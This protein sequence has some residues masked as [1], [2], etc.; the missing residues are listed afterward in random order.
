VSGVLALRT[1]ALLVAVVAL[2]GGCRQGT[3]PVSAPP[4]EPS[5]EPTIQPDDRV[6]LTVYFRNGAG[7]HLVPV[8]REVAVGDDLPRR[9]M[10][11]LLAGPNDEE[12]E[13]GG[14]VAPLPTTTRI[15][16]FTVDSGTAEVDLSAHVISDAQEVGATPENEVLALA[17]IVGTLTEFPAIDR[18]RLAV[19]GVTSGWRGGV[20]VGAFWGGWGLPELLVRDET[21]LGEPSRDADGVPDLALFSGDPQTLGA[22]NGEPVAIHTVRMR[23]RTTYLRLAVGITDPEDPDAPGAVPQARAR[24]DG[25]SILVEIDGVTAYTAEVSAGQRLAV[26]DPAFESLSVELTE[27]PGTVRLRLN[28]AEARSFV[29]HRLSS[30][31]RVVLDVKK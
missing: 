6:D 31:T 3:D 7:G 8:V 26:D 17:A 29:L 25:N 27:L 28:L 2:L 12:V 10:E 4:A 15:L 19:E 16:G 13:S 30:P 18:V 1:A 22:G 14:M 9:A 20:N 24:A 23:S 21:V 11:L 5:P